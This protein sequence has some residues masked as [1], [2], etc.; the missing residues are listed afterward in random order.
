MICE[1]SPSET[2]NGATLPETSGETLYEENCLAGATA[3]VLSR[4]ELRDI[5]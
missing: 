1:R 3:L 2:G 5:L 4:T